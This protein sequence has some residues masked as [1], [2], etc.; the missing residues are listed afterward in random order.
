MKKQH[1]K[2]HFKKSKIAHF[3]SLQ[4]IGGTNTIPYNEITIYGSDCPDT[5]LVSCY[6]P[7]CTTHG[8]P[9]T[10]HDSPCGNTTD[11]NMGSNNDCVNA[12]GNC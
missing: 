6:E 10:N 1:R 12:T 9:R 5:L 8:R 7:G 4:V 3:K 11:I 2:L